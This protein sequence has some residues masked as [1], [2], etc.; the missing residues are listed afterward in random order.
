MAKKYSWIMVAVVLLFLQGCVSVQPP[1]FDRGTGQ[2][3]TTEKSVF[4]LDVAFHN[5][6]KEKY[7]AE[8]LTLKLVKKSS[9]GK[10]QDLYFEVRP[11]LVN[12]E[13]DHRYGLING[14]LEPGEYLID[15]ITGNSTSL[16]IF[17][18]FKI[19]VVESVVIPENSIVYLGEVTAINRERKDGEFRSGLV[20]PLI[21]QAVAGF[22]GGTMDIEIANDLASREA[23][24][25]NEY[26]ALKDKD[27][28]PILL[29]P[30]DRS[31]L[32][33]GAK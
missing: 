8:N 24:L 31:T 25:K 21:D 6:Y 23:D 1:A 29:S 32:D 30:F 18:T 16:L 20:V 10:G 5:A 7:Q 14:E 11:P 15:G 9:S 4:M 28:T 2:I 17:G 22:S 33:S 3:D 26:P 13:N 19:P 27:I 12:S